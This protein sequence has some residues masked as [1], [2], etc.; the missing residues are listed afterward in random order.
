VIRGTAAAA[1]DR[2]AAEASRAA[3]DAGGSAVDA[4]LAGFF[5][6][7]GA[8]AGVLLSPAVALVAGIGAGARA[9]DGRATQPGRGA[10][11]PRGFV[12]AGRVPD[13]ARIAAPRSLSML[14]LLHGYVGR[15][16]L[17][18]LAR[19]GVAAAERAGAPARAALL[20]QI[21]AT[22]AAALQRREVARALLDVGGAIAGGT[23]TEEDLSETL[24]AETEALAI[25]VGAATV[26]LRPPWPVGV[27]ARPAEVIVACDGRGLLAALAY[28]PSDEGVAV[29][30]LELTLC[31]DAI[32]VRRGIPRVIPGTPL[33]AAAPIAILRRGRFAAVVGLPG[34]IAIDQEIVEA[35]AGGVA[36]EAT[37]RELRSAVAVVHDGRDARS[38]TGG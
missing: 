6:A 4:L 22:G 8:R 2:A 27:D 31:L 34:Q 12:G 11:R 5:A 28:A 36:M 25:E 21:G 10:P 26:A 19:A 23:L 1:S 30:E 29:P 24:P 18:E 33:P 37:L 17:R 20:D 35:L 9:F 14:S 32:P 7:A 38:I 15:S 16:R 13:A 3:L